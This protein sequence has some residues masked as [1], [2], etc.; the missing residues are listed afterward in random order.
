[1]SILTNTWLYLGMTLFL[2]FISI[3]YIAA[4][5]LLLE[6]INKKHDIPMKVKFLIVPVRRICQEIHPQLLARRQKQLLI[7]AFGVVIWACYFVALGTL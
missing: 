7:F 4:G 1:M 2:P 5:M 6:K 3:A